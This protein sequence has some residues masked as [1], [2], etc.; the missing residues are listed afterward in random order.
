MEMFDK[1]EDIVNRYED[2]TAELSNPDVVKDSE[3]L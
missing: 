3:S 2:I 1:L